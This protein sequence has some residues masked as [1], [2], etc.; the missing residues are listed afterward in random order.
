V[1]LAA[2]TLTGGGMAG[3]AALTGIENVSGTTFA[4]TI[5]GDAN[6]NAIQGDD[7]ADTIDGAAGDDTLR[8]GLGNDSVVGGDGNDWLIGN[9]GNDTLQGGNGNDLL[10]MADFGLN[11]PGQ[12]VL[13]GGAAE[14]WL[15]YDIVG[16]AFSPVQVNLATGTATGGGMNGAGGATLAN[17]ED[18][19]GTQFNDSITGDAGPNNL[20]GGDG[21]DTVSGGAGND[22]LAGGAGDDSLAGGDGNDVLDGRPGNDTLDGGLGDDSYLVDSA[23]DIVTD[24]GG[25]DTIFAGLSTYTLPDPIE[26]LIFFGNTTV[27]GTG[28][29]LANSLNAGSDAS[30]A[31]LSGLA[32]NDTLSGTNGNDT[33]DGGTGNDTI[34]GAGGN[35]SIIL[36]S[37]SVPDFGNDFVNGGDGFDA[38]LFTGQSSAVSIDM[39]AGTITGGGPGGAG[40][41]TLVSIESIGLTPGANF[42]DRMVAGNSSMLFNGGG[43]DDTLIGGAGNDSLFGGATGSD[44][45]IGGAGNDFLEGDSGADQFVFNATPGTTNADVINDFETGV[46]TIHL[47]GTVMSALGAS[48]SFAATDPRFFAGPGANSAPDG[49]VRV[50]FDTS[51]GN[52]WYDNDGQTFTPPQLIATLNFARPLAAS[53]IVVDNGIVGMRVDGAAGNDSLRGG[54]GQDTINGHDGNDTLI[55]LGGDDTLDGGAGNDIV[56]GSTGSDLLIGGDGNDTLNGIS[57]TDEKSDTFFDGVEA[58]QS[59]DTLDGGLGD[60]FYMVQ[61]ND[62]IAAD[63]GGVDTVQAFHTD[64]TL[65]AGLD[66]LV[67]RPFPTVLE[68]HNATGNELDNTIDATGLASTVLQGLG[69]NDALF[70]SGGSDRLDG[71]DGNDTLFGDGGNDTLIGGAGDDSLAGARSPSFS[72]QDDLLDGGAG[73]DTL[74]GG[75]GHDTVTGGAGSD[76][77]LFDVA[78]GARHADQITD[79]TSGTDR[80]LLDGNVMPM[81]LSGSFSAGDPRFFAGAGATGGH[82]ADDRIVFDTST[83]K[84]YFDSD[85]NGEAAA[86]LIATLQPGASVIATDIAIV[87]GVTGVAIDG[88]AGNDSLAGGVAQDAINGLDG[89]DTIDG[90][91][92]GDRLNGGDGDDSLLGGSGADFLAG[93]D[94]NDT[95][96]GWNSFHFG[97]TDFD[98]DTMVGGLG[99]DFYKLDNPDDVVADTGGTDTVWV[100]NTSWTMAPGIENLLIT[101]GETESHDRFTGNELDNLMDARPRLGGGG[102]NF[103]FDGAGGNDTLFGS[104]HDSVLLGGDGNDL[105]I[106]GDGFHSTMDGGNGDDLLIGGGTVIGGAGN[107]TLDTAGQFGDILTGGAGAD[108]F[109]FNGGSSGGNISDFQPGADKIALDAN[110]MAQL[111]A[112]GTF[113]AGDARF[114]AAAGAN[115]GHDADDRVI[116]N[117]TTGQLWYDADGNGAGAAQLIATLR[118]TPA[119]SAT[120]IQVVNGTP[121]QTINGT[122]GNDS[123]VGGAGNDTISGFDGNDTIDGGAGADN[124]VG[125]TGDDLYFVDNPGDII[126]EQQNEGIDEARAS[127]DYT[128]PAFVNNLTLLG[129]AVNGTGNDIEN[130]ITGNALDNVLNGGDDND[131]LVGGAGNDTLIGSN[132]ANVLDGGAGNDWLGSGAGLLLNDNDPGD[133]LIGG[134]GNDTLVGESRTFSVRGDAGIADTLSGGLGDDVYAVGPNDVIQADP[135]GLD[136]VLAFETDWT[137]GAGLEN[138]TFLDDGNAGGGQNGIGNELDNVLDASGLE[139]GA[140][141][142]GLGG[143]DTLLGGAKATGQL[144]GGD[145]NDL[146]EN[147]S[148]ARGQFM[149]GGNGNDT[150]VGNDGLDIAGDIYSFDVQPGAANADVFARFHAD[151][152]HIQLDGRAMAALGASGTFAADDA[153]FFAAAGANAGHDADDRV[154]Y[155]TTT[156]QLWY[157]ADGN[158]AGAAQLI[159]TVDGAP[160]VTATNIT[161]VNGNAGQTINGTAGNDS[162]VGTPG[163]D[164]IFGFDGN[165]TIDGGAGAD[166]MVGG[167]G[168]D[169]YFVDNPGDIIVEQ[170]TEGVDEARASVDYTLPAFV[171]NLTLVGNA[172]HGTGNDISNVITGNALANVLDGGDASDTLIGGAGN[173][174]LTGGLGSDSLVGG[175]GNDTLVADFAGQSTNFNDTLDGGLGDDTYVVGSGGGIG[176]T[177]RDTILPDPGGFDTVIA[178]H[179]ADWTLGP[180]LDALTFTFDG[181][182]QAVG[183]ELDNVISNAAEIF[184]MGG[185]DR[186]GARFDGSFLHG[187]DG[188]DTLIGSPHRD[189]LSGGAGSDVLSGGG[190]TSTFAESDIFLFDVTPGAANADVVTDFSQSQNSRIQLDGSVM[191][192]L[193]PSGAFAVGDARFFAGAG[194]N[195]GHDADDRV[196]YNTTTGQLWYDADGSGTGAAQLIATLQG[197]PT[198]DPTSISVINGTATP[199]TGTINGTAGN[200]ALTGTAGN[201]TI[202]GLDGNDTIQGLDG[203]DSL[204]GGAGV[205]SID[206]GLGNDTLVATAGDVLTDAGGIDTIVT[207]ANWTMGA[208]FENLTQTGGTNA[209][210]DGNASANVILGNAGNNSIQGGDGNDTIN[211]GAGNDAIGGNGGVDFVSGGA[212]N[213]TVSGGSGQ[214]HFVFDAFGTAN[215]DSLV[216]FATAWDDMRFDSSVFTGL[217]ALGHFTAADARF[218][219]GAG[220]TAGHDA[221]DRIVFNTSTGQLFYDADGSGAGAA[222]LVATAQA[223]A[224]V[225]AGDIWVT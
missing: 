130:L 16:G 126:V 204:D 203:N 124:M 86:Q 117:T 56:V 55:G 89:N 172:T 202:N 22:T 28:N 49:S 23:G 13:D 148:T 5:V 160:A 225:A 190:V 81:G 135:G 188:N 73:N 19:F 145:G 12:D 120:D 139:F 195:A 96:D 52:L 31:F 175:D 48:G 60:D 121:G 166:S 47:D 213:D 70:G 215:A 80:V 64:W 113:A 214:D 147:T 88:T 216:D 75:A 36:G 46:D 134:D 187:G 185:N 25:N 133:L 69:G 138:L 218:F 141:L 119:L 223:G 219:A 57:P 33:F 191:N 1:N 71:G 224:Q 211:G 29:V 102:W 2:G 128:L 162:L 115:A 37:V 66:N 104:G 103:T 45:L 142:Q 3:S 200:D 118:G 212:G 24:A 123:L 59:V 107:D 40:S 6:A 170:S 177:V 14:D 184:G 63:P 209:F 9:D 171:N 30:S 26:T 122:A 62:L 132:G 92:G 74:S 116:Y 155:N 197:A 99:D 112:T 93:G 35:D 85:G 136:S 105:L 18:V 108:Q 210:V 168:D 114:F 156:G 91:D 149:S 79:F 11:G 41:A 129:G 58:T 205:D 150:L 164:T 186:L 15:R 194:A 44:V 220:A 39:S 154:I 222:Q 72:G 201:D 159:A 167:T 34:L 38:I 169:L 144:L 32:G 163:N 50:I 106:R 178:D 97:A 43:G 158:G 143:N 101:N 42:A 131:T 180:G 140:T 67:L 78:P 94:G 17:I 83:G 161:V 53:D 198:L 207:D 182:A 51:T 111:G 77:F 84:L 10:F 146:L 82:D 7:G 196:V 174:S 181:G 217:G 65:G 61:A 183:N 176:T 109:V 21:N 179:T 76:S 4:D 98:V 206:G 192:A 127:V 199:P 54:G 68:S 125:G 110:G 152:D 27:N 189:I 208:A 153:R 8:G 165:D 20:I 221:D 90:G 137:L 193:G 95:L 151:F 87:N 100:R 157:D 173:D